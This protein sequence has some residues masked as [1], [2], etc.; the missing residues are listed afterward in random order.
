MTGTAAATAFVRPDWVPRVAPGTRILVAGASGGL[1][2]ALTAMLLEG[3]DCVI[4][5]HGAS[6]EPP[7][8]DSRVVPLRRAFAGERDCAALVEE[9][10]AKAG[11]LDALVVLTGAIH[12]S[13]HWKT[14]PAESWQRDVEV[15]LSQPF[16]L[17]R[18]AMARMKGQGAGGRI[19]LTGTESALHGGSPVSFPYAVAKRGTECLVQGLAREGAPHGILVNGLRFGY[20]ASGFHERWHKRSEEEMRARAELV[21]LKRGGHPEEAA[22][23]MI[24]LLS[25]WGRYITGQMFPLTGGDWL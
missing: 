6:K 22:A 15:N 16:F 5:A 19:L 12:F 10:V 23:L 20:V 13:G 18:A 11:G 21:P 3:S 7:A 24:F 1:G 8:G 14:M 9:F 2:R 25:D 17:A 4:G